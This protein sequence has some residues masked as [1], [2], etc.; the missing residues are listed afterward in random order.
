M[1]S[2]AQEKGWGMEVAEYLQCCAQRCW[3]E[4]KVRWRYSAAAVIQAR[5]RRMGRQREYANAK[6]PP[7]RTERRMRKQRHVSR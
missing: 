2:A 5:T 6:A 7:G 1:E 3:Q 4:E